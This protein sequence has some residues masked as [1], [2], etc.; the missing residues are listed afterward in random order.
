MRGFTRTS[1]ASFLLSSPLFPNTNSLFLFILPALSPARGRDAIAPSFNVVLSRFTNVFS[2][3]FSSPFLPDVDRY[4]VPHLFNADMLLPSCCSSGERPHH[5]TQC[6]RAFS[7][8][9]S[10]ARHRRIQCVSLPS[11]R[12]LHLDADGLSYAHSTGMRPY[13]C[14]IVECAKTYVSPLF[15]P[16]S[17]D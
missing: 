14:E 9:S 4:L 8:S 3:S 6:D 13:K 7:D 12:G 5:C 2:T 11:V 16:F 10:L 17:Q 1:G 15:L